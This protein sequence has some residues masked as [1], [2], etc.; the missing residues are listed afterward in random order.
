MF[1][2]AVISLRSMAPSINLP[3]LLLSVLSTAAGCPAGWSATSGSA[4]FR[5]TNQVVEHRGCNALCGENAAL[6]C[7]QSKAEND[8]V[9]S[10]LLDGDAYEVWIGP[11]QWPVDASTDRVI[12]DGYVATSTV[13]W[14]KCATGES[15]HFTSW[16]VDQDA[17]D[18]YSAAKQSN[19]AQLVHS[20]VRDSYVWQPEACDEL[21]QCLCQLGQ[22]DSPEYLAVAD[23]LATERWTPY[24]VARANQWTLITFLGLFPLL[25]LVLTFGVLVCCCGLRPPCCRRRG[26]ASGPKLTTRSSRADESSEARLEAVELAAASLRARVTIIG[27]AIG[28]TCFALALLPLLVRTLFR[29]NTEPAMGQWTYYLIP[30][31][32]A[33]FFGFIVVRPTDDK[34]VHAMST[35]SV[36]AN[37]LMGALCIFQGQSGV[38]YSSLW[39]IWCFTAVGLIWVF[40]ALASVTTFD[41]VRALCGKPAMPT[42]S[43]LMRMWQA[44][45]IF[46]TTAGLIIPFARANDCTAASC[47][48]AHPLPLPAVDPSS[49]LSLASQS[50]HYLGKSHRIQLLRRLRVDRMGYA[51]IH[52][53]MGDRRNFCY[54]KQPWS[55]GTMARRAR[56]QGCHQGE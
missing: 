46:F 54:S 27:V 34:A 9:A 55:R 14:D 24:G 26:G 4:C 51:R 45:R 50:W 12:E 40:I 42:R 3:P 13:G 5:L 32:F 43:K 29:V 1:R 53:S 23:E 21:R 22:D 52:V 47:H 39:T 31:A 19:C 16:G 33:F 36:L 2:T 15:V 41:C 25:T 28:C 49:F 30:M 20:K 44:I 7:F 6:A 18:P 35:V 37:F 8:E 38:F 56:Q 11:Y 10:L 17:Q 48:P